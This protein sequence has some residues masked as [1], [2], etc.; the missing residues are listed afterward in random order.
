MQIN[1]PKDKIELIQKNFDLIDKNK[2]GLINDEEFKILV[3]LLGQTKT[4]RELE[5]CIETFFEDDN[6]DSEK[7]EITKKEQ[8]GE[9][10]KNEDKNKG[11][12]EGKNFNVKEKSPNNKADKNAIK[13]KYTNN[14]PT[15]YFNDDNKIPSIPDRFKNKMSSKMSSKVSGKMGNKLDINNNNNNKTT[16]N[17]L[18]KKKNI[19]FETFLKIFIE[20][21]TEPIPLD[22]LVKCFKIFDNEKTGYINKEKLEY[23][24][25]NCDEKINEEDIK[26]F[27]SLSNIQ[28]KKNI[29]Y[30]KL[31]IKLKEICP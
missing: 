18:K 25:R 7:E 29:D 9:Q 4:E 23:I 22:Y 28:N 11:K 1:L 6:G 20:T 17:E 8:N 13:T 3:R 5:Q 31:S 16:N 10:N 30:V 26:L 24:L 14:G 27:L 19:N 21:Y 2:D 15:K 12:D